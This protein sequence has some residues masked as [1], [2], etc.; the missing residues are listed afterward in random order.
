MDHLDA[1]KAK[2][3]I[4]QSGWSAVDV[5]VAGVPFAAMVYRGMC[6]TP[7]RIALMNSEEDDTKGNAAILEAY[8]RLAGICT[9]VYEIVS[10]NDIRDGILTYSSYEFLWAPHWE[11]YKKYDLDG[12]GDGISDVE[13]IVQKIRL[14]LESGKGLLAECASIETFEHSNNGKFLTTEGLGHNGGTNDSDDIIYL[15]YATPN[16]QIG[17]F[18]YKPERGHLHN[19]RPYQ[20]G[21]P[22]NFDDPPSEASAY[23][24]TV[25]RF[26][27]DNTGWDYYVGGHMDGDI[28][29]GYAVYL[30]G[31]AYAKCDG[32]IEVDPEPEAHALDFEFVTE[33]KDPTTTITMLFEYENDTKSETVTFA[34]GDLTPIVGDELEIDLTTASIR[35]K[36]LLKVTLRNK[37]TANLTVNHITVSWNQDLDNIKKITDTKTDVKIWEHEDPSGTRLDVIDFTI[38]PG[39]GDAFAA[40]TNNSDCEWKN[41]AGVK[42][43]L[44]TLFNIKYQIPDHNYMCAAPVVKHPYIYQGIF[45]YPSYE[46]HFCRY[47]VT[48]SSATAEWDTANRI[49][50]AKTLNSDTDAR[51]VFTAVHGDD[52]WDEWEEDEWGIIDFDSKNIDTLRLALDLTPDNDDDDDE[53]KIINRLRGKVWDVFNEEW[54]EKSN[55]L[56][57]IMHS[58]SVIVEDNT[59][60]SRMPA[61]G[62]IAYVGDVHGMLHAIKTSTGDEKWAFI[63]PNLMGRIKNDRT[64]PV[65]VKDFAAVDGSPTAKDVFFDHDG[66]GDSEWRTI[67]VCTEGFGGNYLFA[68]DVTDPN[69][70]SYLWETTDP[71]APGGGMGHAYRCAINRVKEPVLNEDEELI[72]YEGKYMVFVA[73]GYNENIIVSEHGGSM[74]SHLILQ[75]AQGCGIFPRNTPMRLMISPELS[76]SLTMMVTISW[77]RSMWET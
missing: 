40:C 76:P 36:K 31:H 64:D 74:F 12:D 51:Q 77:T 16:S 3:I 25:T 23:N 66:D 14:F 63:P 11:G 48:D 61:R 59:Q 50:E 75:R 19:W 42:Y 5:H 6:G 73:T 55:R 38:E 52:E 10:P 8:L 26:T 68:L 32:E 18:K 37:S 21:D 67:L 2:T 1:E 54:H 72:G 39:G 9:D 57:G 22:Y 49:K 27:I 44:N 58:A 45:E 47:L 41:V 60:N 30:G 65:A 69:N 56:G 15:D 46:G 43:I 24:E 29:K 71:Y 4:N 33:S 17:D 70:W 62:E 20:S 28:T 35:K 13:E 53:I 7:P 34:I